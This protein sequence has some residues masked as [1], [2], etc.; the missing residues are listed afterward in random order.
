MSALTYCGWEQMKSRW[1]RVPGTRPSISATKL[2]LV[3]LLA[4]LFAR[5]KVSETAIARTMTRFGT[6][7][8]RLS[9]GSL[10]WLGAARVCGSFTSVV[11]C[12]P[13]IGALIIARGFRSSMLPKRVG[14]VAIDVDILVLR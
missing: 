13:T 12:I 2:L 14:G 3:T 7:L 11:L 4:A 5:S 9:I 10:L 8:A 6:V 1:G